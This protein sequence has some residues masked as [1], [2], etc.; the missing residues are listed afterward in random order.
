MFIT[1][2][3]AVLGLPL[4]L[5]V[6]TFIASIILTIFICSLI[7]IQR[8][9]QKNQ[10]EYQIDQIVAEAKNMYE[11]ADDGSLIHKRVEFPGSMKMLVF[12]ALPTQDE[13]ISPNSTIDEN[14]SNN[15]YYIMDN[16]E[17]FT[18]H[19]SVRFSSENTT[20]I[21]VLYP[22][23]YDITIELQTQDGKTYVTIYT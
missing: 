9:S 21:A 17:I 15:Y 3:K 1:D 20:K 2:Q 6:A 22:G 4:F 23:S 11:Y 10:I 5:T 12:G 14:T 13:S 7:N 18:F 8:D 16:E 19:S